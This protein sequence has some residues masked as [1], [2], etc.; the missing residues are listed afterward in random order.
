VGW[1]VPLLRTISAILALRNESFSIS[2]NLLLAGSR[3]AVVRDL[4][5]EIDNCASSGGALSSRYSDNSGTAPDPNR[6][7]CLIIPSRTS[8]RQIEGRGNPGSAARI[9]SKRYERVQIVIEP[10]AVR[11]HQLVNLR[12]P[13]CPTAVACHAQS[14]ASARSVSSPSAPAT[15]RA[16]W[17][18]SSVFVRRFAK[19]IEYRIVKT[20]RRFCFQA[21]KR[22]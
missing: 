6:V 4:I 22:P 15:V 11:A 12:S 8:K 5:D 17:A 7:N 1:S 3:S 2:S 16:I 14:S 13:A 10:A 18:T 19:V 21:P 20:L 9:G